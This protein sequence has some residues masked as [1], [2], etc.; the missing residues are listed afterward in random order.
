MSNS[1][2]VLCPYGQHTS[3]DGSRQTTHFNNNRTKGWNTC[4]LTE[5]CKNKTTPTAP[6][7][8]KNKLSTEALLILGWCFFFFFSPFQSHAEKW[9]SGLLTT[10][11][12]CFP[13]KNQRHKRI[14]AKNNKKI[15]IFN[16]RMFAWLIDAKK[17]KKN[18]PLPGNKPIASWS[19]LLP[20]G[21]DD[22]LQQYIKTFEREKVGGDQL[23]RITHQELEDLGV[24]RIGHQELILE[25]VDLLCALVSPNFPH[26]LSHTF[27]LLQFGRSSSGFSFWTNPDMSSGAWKA[28]VVNRL[29][30]RLDGAEKWKIDEDARRDRMAI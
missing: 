28:K 2:G 21:L 9:S 3:K 15:G 16:A 19:C 26:G 27:F 7:K 11:I 24:S 22:C 17:K 4:C 6:P 29:V 25:A 18:A 23:L 8:K 14:Y 12:C 5:R 13:Q 1:Q 10:A 30:S 20:S